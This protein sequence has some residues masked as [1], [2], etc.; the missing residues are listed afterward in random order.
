VVTQLAQDDVI[1]FDCHD[2]E[3]TRIPYPKALPEDHGNVL[4]RFTNDNQ[5]L[6]L[7]ADSGSLALLDH[8]AGVS[9][10]FL[11]PEV[12]HSPYAMSHCN[13]TEIACLSRTGDITIYDIRQGKPLF[14]GVIEID[15]LS[16]SSKPKIQK[17][18]NCLSVSG[19]HGGVNVYELQGESCVEIFRHTGHQID[20]NR[21][22]LLVTDHL[23]LDH[24][25]DNFIIS[26]AING[27]INC[28]QFL[29]NK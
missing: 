7:N 9:T 21:D 17:C 14:D 26:C 23:W 2:M 5:I 4:C 12:S 25:D 19:V 10:S 29:A 6:L 22:N 13:K 24:I 18:G 3:A 15:E 8:R 20:N 27:S 1:I 16:N 28:W 11:G